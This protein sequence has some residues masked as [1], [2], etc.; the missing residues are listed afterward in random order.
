[1]HVTGRHVRSKIL[2][3]NETLDPATPYSG[4]LKIRQLFPTASLIEGVGGT[5]HSGSLSGVACTDDTIGQYLTD[6]T[7]PQ[8]VPGNRSDLQCPPVPQPEPADATAQRRSAGSSA[9][10]AVLAQLRRTQVAQ[11][12]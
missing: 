9:D 10:A 5:T 6:G 2:L 1:M 3:V 11:L 4:A 7:V 12:R 8:R